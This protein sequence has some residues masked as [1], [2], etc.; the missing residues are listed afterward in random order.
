MIVVVLVII[1]A[2]KNVK[3]A[4]EEQSEKLK[5]GWVGERY[6]PVKI[7][8]D[9]KGFKKPTIKYRTDMPNLKGNYKKYLYSPRSIFVSHLDHKALKRKELEQAVLNYRKVI[10][11]ASKMEHQGWEV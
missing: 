4:I 6:P 5:I 2:L 10:I 8:C 3:T 7:N 11:E 9:P 1:R